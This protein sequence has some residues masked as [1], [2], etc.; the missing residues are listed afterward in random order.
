MFSLIG[1]LPYDYCQ[2]ASVPDE[3]VEQTDSRLGET[4]SVV[5]RSIIPI[6]PII[7]PTFARVD[8]NQPMPRGVSKDILE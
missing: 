7:H 4:L 2:V 1:F 3:M 8:A 6:V 5:M